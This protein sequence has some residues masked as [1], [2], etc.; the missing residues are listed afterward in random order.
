MTTPG[1]RI[2]ALR[3]EKGMTQEELAHRLGLS[4]RTSISH[5]ENGRDIPRSL[6]VELAEI[7]EVSPLYIQCW[8]DEKQS[9]IIEI[10]NS[11]S[12]TQ[13]DEVKDFLSKYDQKK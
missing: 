5:Y 13:L 1:E 9:D 10:I 6:I 8:I 12:D 11:L 4:S 7:F 2:K 3:E